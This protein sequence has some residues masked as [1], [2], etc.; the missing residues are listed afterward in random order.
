MKRINIIKTCIFTVAAIASFG[1][2]SISSDAQISPIFYGME[3]P[4]GRSHFNPAFGNKYNYVSIPFLG[5]INAQIS[6]NVGVSNFIYKNGKDKNISFLHPNI[7][8]DKFLRDLPNTSSIFMGLDIPILESG[9]KLL[10]GYATVGLKMKGFSKVEAPK[11]LFRFMKLGMTNEDGTTYNIDNVEMSTF[12]T[13]DLML[14]YSRDINCKLRVGANV[15]FLLGSNALCANVK[16]MQ[17]SMSKDQYIIHNEEGAFYH[18]KIVETQNKVDENGKELDEIDF[19]ETKF[20]GRELDKVNGFGMAVDLGAVYKLRD[21][22]DLSASIINLGAVKIN[23]LQVDKIKNDY[24]FDGFTYDPNSKESLSDQAESIKDE[25]KEFYKF[26]MTDKSTSKS[27]VMP[28]MFNLGAKYKM[29]FYKGLYASALFHSCLNYRAGSTGFL[30]AANIEPAKW[31]SAS[32]STDFANTGV[33]PG[34]ALSFHPR[35]FNFFIGAENAFTKFAKKTLA[36]IDKTD[37]RLSMGMDIL[38]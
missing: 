18:S 26:K 1:V 13:Y 38:F 2:T 15:H 32:I 24:S 23:N 30:I 12:D 19:N 37:F 33:R 7:D 3:G 25:L 27:F 21:D 28:I 16:N 5:G 6:T 35:G 10:G 29:P 36:P 8:A 9:F 17:I 11:E 20:H 34:I 22:L 31:F 14:G 4:A